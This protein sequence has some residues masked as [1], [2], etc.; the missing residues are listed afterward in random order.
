MGM[1]GCRGGDSPSA[2][3]SPSVC[4]ERCVD[5]YA[6]LLERMWAKLGRDGH[7]PSA[8]ECQPGG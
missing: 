8:G 5:A 6:A 3:L 4:S 1:W 2:A 7:G